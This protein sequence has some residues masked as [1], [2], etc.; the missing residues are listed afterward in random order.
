MREYRAMELF[1]FDSVLG[2]GTS[3]SHPAIKH[4]ASLVVVAIVM[5]PQ[6]P[7]PNALYG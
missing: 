1:N 2:A 6:T 5:Q 7:I 3:P 4:N